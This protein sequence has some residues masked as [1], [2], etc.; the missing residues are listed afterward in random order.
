MRRKVRRSLAWKSM[1][2][3]LV[4]HEPHVAEQL[5]AGPL[6]VAF[7]GTARLSA[8]RGAQCAPTVVDLS[9]CMMT[10]SWRRSPR[11]PPN[12]LPHIELTLDFDPHLA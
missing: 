9:V 5:V 10:F 7:R 11:T 6:A 4:E 3:P 8:N 2:W 12:S 1:E